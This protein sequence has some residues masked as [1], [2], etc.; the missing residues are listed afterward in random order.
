MFERRN[1]PTLVIASIYLLAL[2]VTTALLVFWVAVVQR[3]DTEIN[4]LIG[5]LGVEWNY[6]HWFIQSFG[7]GLFFLVFVALTI[8]LAVTLAERRYSRKQEQFLS[9]MTHD[10]KSPVAAIKL[11]AQTLQ[12]ED[13]NVTERER[14]LNYIVQEAERVG[15]LV[16]N[17]L[18]SSRA[19]A[20]GAIH[21]LQPI[22][23]HDFFD[24][25]Q[26]AVRGRFDLREIDLRFEVHTRTV[27]MATTESLGRM[28][29]NLI[30][31]AVRFTSD[32]GQVTC[33]V[34]DGDDGAEIVVAD[35]GI[36]IPRRDL[37]RIFE[38]FYRTGRIIQGRQSGTGLGLAIVRDLVD[39]MRG[40]I[41][42]FSGPDRPGTRFEIRLPR[43][44][45]DDPEATTS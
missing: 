36:G 32:G 8:L 17:L 7:A 21:E 45:G 28:M 24:E 22:S 26:E 41:Q 3:F 35:T 40:T 16:D 9:S 23:L 25:Y 27:V 31:N 14:F 38:R 2:A 19:A 13:V 42:A 30:D 10:L 12:Q 20:G 18:A 1:T 39:E 43:T 44:G 33:E 15:T 6:F 37:S 11:H 5:R 34:R 4:Q 29:D